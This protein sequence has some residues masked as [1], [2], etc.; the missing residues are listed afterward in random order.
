MLQTDLDR[1]M[2]AEI[3][4]IQNSNDNKIISFF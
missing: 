1:N 3:N 2:Q 4:E